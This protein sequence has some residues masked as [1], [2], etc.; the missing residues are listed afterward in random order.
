MACNP[1]KKGDV[2]YVIF[3]L[4]F[5]S[6][7]EYL[8]LEIN[9]QVIPVWLY[10]MDNLLNI[11]FEYSGQHK[12]GV[13]PGLY[14]NEHPGDRWTCQTFYGLKHFNLSE[15]GSFLERK[16]KWQTGCL[17]IQCKGK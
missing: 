17:M 13:L 3:S 6:Y 7:L 14:V 11:S 16:F 4:A 5:Q 10:Q 2:I 8:L 1:A 12:Y 9:F 15:P